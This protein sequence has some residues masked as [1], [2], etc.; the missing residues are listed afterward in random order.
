VFAHRALALVI[1]LRI[2]LGSYRQL[3]ELPDALFRPV[4]V[5]GWLPSMPPAG[6]I[7]A[8]Q[9]AGTVAAGLAVARRWPRAAF[10]VAWVAY[11]VLAGLRGSRGK[12][13]HN[14]LLLLWVGA[15]FLCAPV[16]GRAVRGRAGAASDQAADRRPSR[17]AG[18]PLRLAVVVTALVYL[19]AG[20]HKLRRSGPGWIVG[21]NMSW[22]MRWGPSIG[23]T[24][25]PALTEWV[26]DHHVAAMVSAA[27]IIGVELA[28]PLVVW[29]RWLRPWFAAAAVVLH[30][31]TWLLLGLDYWAWALTVPIVLVDWPAAVDRWRERGRGT[32]PASLRV[33][34]PPARYGG[35]P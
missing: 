25:L 13:L 4:P 2:A 21:D 32:D 31:G 14:D 34:G 5:L 8:I 27:F 20:Y 33:G 12:V 29:H 17:A 18:W 26:G 16:A 28:F 9:L 23:D 10:A 11:L 3:A 35:L 30:V 7:V 22:V 15:C 19:F 1:G 24:P 6:A